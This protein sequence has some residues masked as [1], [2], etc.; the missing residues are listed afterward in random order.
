[1]NNAKSKSVF[2]SIGLAVLLFFCFLADTEL[3][4]ANFCDPSDTEPP[5]IRCNAPATITPVDAPISFTATV[6]DNCDEELTVEITDYDCF[7]FTKKGKRI[8]RT[9]SCTVSLEGD[10]INIIDSGGVG[11]IITWTSVSS[12]DWGNTTERECLIV[13]VRKV[14]P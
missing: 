7:S 13:V 11:D 3:A 1:M 2:L 5:D 6:T 14:I 4:R 8:D 9:E 12:D 10:T